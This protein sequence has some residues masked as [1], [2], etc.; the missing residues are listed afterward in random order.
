MG[1]ATKDHGFSLGLKS[2]GFFLLR[3]NGDIIKGHS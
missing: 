2:E 3:C 1:V